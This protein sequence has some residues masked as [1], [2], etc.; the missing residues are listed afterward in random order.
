[1]LRRVVQQ[2]AS[3][4]LDSTPA[5]ELSGLTL[6]VVGLG[7]TGRA[8]AKLANAFG[9]RVW[10][11]SRSPASDDGDIQSRTLN[12][13]LEEA[14][15]ITVHVD[16]VGGRGVLGKAQLDRIRDGIL[17]VNVAFPDAIVCEDLRTELVSGRLRAAYDAPPEGD[18]SDLP[19]DC[20]FSSIRQTAFNTREANVR[21]GDHITRAVIEVLTTGTSGAV[22]NPEFAASR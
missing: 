15:V 20:F 10:G 1:M 5:R 18:Y 19:A 11:Y 2:A 21:A 4:S 6:G 16:R 14:D 12:E 13:L 3:G 22:V 17:V 9:M 7:R 8:V